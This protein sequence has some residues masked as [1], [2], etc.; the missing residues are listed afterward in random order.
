MDQT[1]F[2]LSDIQSFDR[3]YRATLINTLSGFKS[4]NLVGTT[5]RN[6]SFNLAIF[7]SV[8]HLGANPPL[9]GMILRPTSVPRHT[10]ENLSEVGYYTINHIH[11]GIFE[12]AHQT[13]AKYEC[14]SSEFDACGFTPE[15]RDQHPAPYVRESFIK[16]GMEYVEEYLIEANKTRL[17]VG[18]VIELILPEGSI[19][20]DGYLDLAAFETVSISG[21]DAYYLPKPLGRRAYA[22]PDEAPK[23]L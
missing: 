3:R 16:I 20:A 8:V 22:R 14:G 4:A 11:Q 5:D 9:L 18:K 17:I 19:E 6:G 2:S 1:V 10:Y 23:A 13:S 12:K 15:V 21:L 7:N